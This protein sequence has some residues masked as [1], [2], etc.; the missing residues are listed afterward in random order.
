[1]VCFIEKP[2]KLKNKRV[3]DLQLGDTGYIPHHEGNTSLIPS[4]KVNNTH[5]NSNILSFQHIRIFKY[6]RLIN[7][8]LCLVYYLQSLS[9]SGIA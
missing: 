1:M 8:A 5:M 9:S 2:Q 6:V 4:F 7:D 3:I